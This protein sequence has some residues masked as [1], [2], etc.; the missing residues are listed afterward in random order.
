MSVTGA[1]LRPS[2]SLHSAVQVEPT[3]AHYS[4]MYLKSRNHTDS[5]WSTVTEAGEADDE[6]QSR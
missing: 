2:G 3:L 4:N 1:G 5:M 6:Q